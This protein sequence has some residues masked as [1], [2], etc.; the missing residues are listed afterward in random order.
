MEKFLFAIL[1]FFL[2]GCKSEVDKCLDAEM[3]GWDAQQERIAKKIEQR[4]KLND[5]KN[6]TAGNMGKGNAGSNFLENFE[7][8][9][10]GALVDTERLDVRSREEVI[11]ER[12]YGCLRAINKK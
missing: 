11:A 8:S 7:P 6:L 12:R 3:A 4:Q 5:K 2:V 9:L 10:L 1:V